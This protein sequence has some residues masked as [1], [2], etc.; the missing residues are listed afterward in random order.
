[1]IWRDVASSSLIVVLISLIAVACSFDP[2]ACCVA[3]ACSS[4]D[5]LC[6]WPTAVPICRLKRARQEPPHAGDEG[7][8][9]QG[10][11]TDGQR[12]AARRSLHVVG[13]LLEQPPLLSVH[14]AEDST[15]F[16]HDPLAPHRACIRFTAALEASTPTQVDDEFQLDQPAMRIERFHL[17]QALLSALVI[18]RQRPEVLH[19]GSSPQRFPLDIARGT[20][21]RR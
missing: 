13:A 2:V 8:G 3:A 6:T 16:V 19:H 7:Q 15:Q 11:G 4:A 17:A 10:A 12:G 14:V 1:M 21:H 20:C 5:E 18:G 9:E